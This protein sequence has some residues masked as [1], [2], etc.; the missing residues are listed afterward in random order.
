M[1]SPRFF[2]LFFIS[3]ELWSQ[4]TYILSRKNLH[5]ERRRGTPP[6]VNLYRK[7]Y[8]GLISANPSL[9]FCISLIPTSE[10]GSRTFGKA[11]ARGF[12]QKADVCSTVHTVYCAHCIS[13]VPK[14]EKQGIRTL[15]NPC[16][17]RIGTT[18][19]DVNPSLPRTLSPFQKVYNFKDYSEFL[20][21]KW[22]LE[23]ELRTTAIRHTT[24]SKNS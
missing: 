3:F 5:S 11:P 8:V 6:R 18:Q 19:D 14:L 22:S 23:I 16:V 17:R 7:S 20:G 2:F 1:F 4:K 24:R 12:M 21:G 13:F 15:L 9:H 10:G